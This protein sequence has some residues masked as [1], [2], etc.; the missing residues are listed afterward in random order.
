VIQW[1]TT[2]YFDLTLIPYDRFGAWSE[3]P[4][5][6]AFT[7][8]SPG[9]DPYVLYVGKCES[10][11]QRMCGHPK[12]IDA[13]YMGANTVHAAVV[14]YPWLLDHF[15]QDLIERLNPPLNVQHRTAP[16]GV[17]PNL[18]DLPYPGSVDPYS[19]YG[20]NT[21]PRPLA[22]GLRRR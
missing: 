22:S 17:N 11:A 20:I 2:S 7:R 5:I 15:E 13:F 6:Y 8:V 9:C 3:S 1:R 12:W 16:A 21:P 18:F 19:L 4:G 14:P 10:F